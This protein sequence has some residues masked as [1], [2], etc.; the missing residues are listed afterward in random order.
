MPRNMKIVIGILAIAVAIGLV[1]FRSLHQRIKRFAAA[2]AVD[3]QARHEV[4]APPISTPTDVTVKA[5]IFWASG[6][7]RIAPVEIELPLSADR[8]ER[9]RQL[10]HVLAAN[11]PTP[12]QRTIPA[13]TVLWVS[14]FF[15]MA[16]PS[17]ISPT[18]S[19][20]KCHRD[21]ERRDGGQFHRTNTWEQ[22]ACPSAPQDSDPWARSGYAGGECRPYWFF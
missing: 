2:Q 10:M 3:E 8:V 4:L 20:T 17:R 13:D 6:P 1:S 22:S 12:D 21:P 18:H 15:P 5:K 16:R 11:P 19:P 9:S 7:D 14:T